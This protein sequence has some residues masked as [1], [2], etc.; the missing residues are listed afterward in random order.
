MNQARGVEA[1]GCLFSSVQHSGCSP[2]SEEEEVFGVL[3]SHMCRMRVPII[4]YIT[5]SV[6]LEM[7]TYTCSHWDAAVYQA[8]VGIIQ[9]LIKKIE[10]L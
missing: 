1:P 4:R 2:A 8:S 5:T 10:G 7:Y 9:A 3:L 6:T